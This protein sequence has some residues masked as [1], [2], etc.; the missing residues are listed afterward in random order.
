MSRR[1]RNA[2][3]MAKCLA[4][5]GPLLLVICSSY[6]AQTERDLVEFARRW[7]AVKKRA[8]LSD[9]KTAFWIDILRNGPPELRAGAARELSVVG[10]GRAEPV[11]AELASTGR[12]L[13]GPDCPYSAHM[14]LAELRARLLM[15][16][17]FLHAHTV[18]EQVAACR[19]IIEKDTSHVASA[20]VAAKLMAIDV[21]EALPVLCRLIYLTEVRHRVVGMG[22]AAL[23][24]LYDI[25]ASGE[26][27]LVAP[28]VSAFGDIGHASS[29][30]VIAP[31]LFTGTVV[32]GEYRTELV[33][34]RD[35]AESALVEFGDRAIPALEKVAQVRDSGLLRSVATVLRRIGTP[36]A[37]ALRV[38][39][40]EREQRLDRAVVD[41]SVLRL[42]ES[43]LPA[44]RPEELLQRAREM[45]RQGAKAVSIA[46]DGRAT[47]REDTASRRQQNGGDLSLSALAEQVKRVA[48]TP[49]SRPPGRGMVWRR[50]FSV[51]VRA[52]K[53]LEELAREY[54][55]LFS[56][57]EA[58]SGDWKVQ[59][60]AGIVRERVRH[61]SEVAA[62]ARARIEVAHS[63]SWWRRIATVGDEIAKRG[64]SLPM[65]LTESFWKDNE[66]GKIEDPG[67]RVI[68]TKCYV[69]YA[70]G[71][72][73]V[74]SAAR[75]LEIALSD[76]GFFPKG[77]EDWI[78]QRTRVSVEWALGQIGAPS[79][80]AVLLGLLRHG[81]GYGS[82]GEAIWK[83]TTEGNIHLLQEYCD[84]MEDEALRSATLRKIEEWKRQ[85]RVQGVKPESP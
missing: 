2:F 77:C 13:G 18:P 81:R 85:H 58:S 67:F 17:E 23:P 3:W 43:P 50:D 73:R 70:L 40:L 56:Q 71:V 39:I 44:V 30:D 47:P 6:A 16:R 57:L 24:Y 15:E 21:P 76:D 53:E 55:R 64:R 32:N 9:D 61:S 10:D 29:L 80:L 62:L 78:V 54:P 63:R 31:L 42:L 48:E 38:Q 26:V 65:F 72:L 20:A 74:K 12:P 28:C 79:S 37:E 49:G 4:C 14:C 8:Q 82:T 59:L 27:D 5:A 35:E 84:E 7:Q 25:C 41:A 33:R 19:R 51:Y 34:I 60:L 1:S 69:A 11:L 46:G 45:I 36:K 75:P 22:K 83:C 52:R 66:F 68:E